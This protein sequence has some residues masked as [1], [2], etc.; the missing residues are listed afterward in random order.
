M[1]Y[2]WNRGR[3]VEAEALVEGMDLQ[4]RRHN[5]WG[6]NVVREPLDRRQTKIR[7]RRHSKPMHWDP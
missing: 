2:P 4:A 6:D 5:T 3:V 1:K 7:G